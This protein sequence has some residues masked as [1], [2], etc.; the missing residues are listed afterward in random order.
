VEGLLGHYLTYTA[1]TVE[2][3]EKSVERTDSMIRLMF[4]VLTALFGVG[5]YSAFQSYT[6][7]RK[8]A[9]Q[10]DR[11]SSKLDETIENVGGLE[12]SCSQL[13]ERLS[14]SIKR[15]EGIEH[16]KLW[17]LGRY[18]QDASE[19]LIVLE[20]EVKL[21]S[22]DDEIRA[23]AEE[24]LLSRLESPL[25][26]IRVAAS[27]AILRNSPSEGATVRV[28]TY[29]AGEEDGAVKAVVSEALKQAQKA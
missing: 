23:I 28:A 14:T 16:N 29:L 9:L 27:R 7:T 5:S 8:T 11:V 19:L 10:A 4:V 3:V 1:D 20:A 21:R 26:A 2:R 17:A 18:T 25:R 22:P 12:T 13:E 24:E 6:R 15:V